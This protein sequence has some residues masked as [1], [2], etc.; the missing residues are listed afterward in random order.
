MGDGLIVDVDLIGEL[1]DGGE[2]LAVG[3]VAAD[4]AGLEGVGD[5]GVEGNA[6][7]AGE[8]NL[9]GGSLSY[10]GFWIGDWGLGIGEWVDFMDGMD[11]M[12]VEMVCQ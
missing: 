11:G 12:D 6:V 3:N 4:N 10:F 7:I 1:A 9:H 2:G 8:G 5:L